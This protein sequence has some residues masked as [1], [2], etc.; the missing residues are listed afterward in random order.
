LKPQSEWDAAYAHAQATGRQETHDALDDSFKREQLE[1]LKADR[2][3]RAK[4]DEE[5]RVSRETLA[6]ESNADRRDKAAKALSDKLLG[7]GNTPDSVKAHDAALAAGKP[8]D[9][10]AKLLRHSAPALTEKKFEMM[11]PAIESN[12]QSAGFILPGPLSEPADVPKT[13][14]TA[15]IRRDTATEGGKTLHSYY[16]DERENNPNLTE[17]QAWA[18][19]MKRAGVDN[20]NDPS[21]GA[22]LQKEA[23]AEAAKDTKHEH[24]PARDRWAWWNA[25]QAD[26]A[27]QTKG[28]TF[29]PTAAKQFGKMTVAQIVGIKVAQGYPREEVL[30]ELRQQGLV[31]DIPAPTAPVASAKP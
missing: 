11:A 25:A 30:A 26:L 6:R 27:Q 21:I 17:P 28:V 3:A 2:I 5:N 31:Q 9:E 18:K 10:A 7:E 20:V 15:A 22:K 4:N 23:D 8:G 14:T 29:S 24:G 12:L 16:E 1:A 19:A 13:K